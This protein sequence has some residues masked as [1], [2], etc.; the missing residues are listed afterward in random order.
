MEMLCNIVIENILIA[1]CGPYFVLRY[2]NWETD[3]I[4]G[5][6]LYQNMITSLL[7]IF[8]TVLVFLGS[9]RASCIVIFCV[10]STILEVAGFMHFWG[11]TIDVISCNTLVISIGLCVDF[12]AHIAHG[13]LTRQGSRNQRVSFTLTKVGPAVLNG[14]L[15][16]LLAF[17]LLSS[18]E[19]YV[20]LSFFKIFFLICIFGLYNGLVTLPVILTIFGPV[21]QVSSNTILNN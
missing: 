2:S 12:S 8:L 21:P 4:I 7:A 15:S 1:N 13:F 9:L 5:R 17:I 18:S 16:T 20:C 14:G 6:E 11:L 10:A 3:K 19:S